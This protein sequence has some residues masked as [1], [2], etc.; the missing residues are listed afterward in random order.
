MNRLWLYNF[1][2]TV[3]CGAVCDN[4]PGESGGSGINSCSDTV[5]D[6]SGI[7]GGY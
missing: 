4:G 1:P 3:H 5:G 7:G 2:A 6:T